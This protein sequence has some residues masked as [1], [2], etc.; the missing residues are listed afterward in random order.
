MRR[1]TFLLINL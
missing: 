1:D